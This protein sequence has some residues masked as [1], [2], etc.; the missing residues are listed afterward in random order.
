MG[1]TPRRRRRIRIGAALDLGGKGIWKH[2]R[3]VGGQTDQRYQ[4]GQLN[5]RQINEQMSICCRIG[6]SFPSSSFPFRLR[7]SFSQTLDY[8]LDTGRFTSRPDNLHGRATLTGG[9]KLGG[10]GKDEH[11]SV[12]CAYER[13]KQTQNRWMLLRYFVRMRS[14][15]QEDKL[16][17][18]ISSVMGRRVRGIAARPVG[19]R[20]ARK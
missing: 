16:D 4:P 15:K 10:S 8:L 7:P 3:G 9:E 17:K 12:S 20:L 11:R 18:A 1:M 6:T 2:G 5:V 19:R 14:A 13:K